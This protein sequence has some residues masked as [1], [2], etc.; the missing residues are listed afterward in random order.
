MTAQAIQFP[1]LHVMEQIWLVFSAVQQATGANNYNWHADYLASPPCSLTDP[2]LSGLFRCCFNS[3]L[4]LPLIGKSARLQYSKAYCAKHHFKPAESCARKLFPK[5]PKRSLSHTLAACG[6]SSA[7]P[8]PPWAKSHCQ[9]HPGHYGNGI[10][11]CI[12][13]YA[14]RNYCFGFICFCWL[15]PALAAVA[16]GGFCGCGLWWP[17]VALCGTCWLSYTPCFNFFLLST[18]HFDLTCF[19]AKR[20]FQYFTLSTPYIIQY[21]I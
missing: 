10:L 21:F 17:D 11:T 5:S 20:V 14:K 3:V 2:W 9:L 12:N 18:S 13:Y 19:L 4:S 7:L 15:L 8:S 6:R 16:F 1:E